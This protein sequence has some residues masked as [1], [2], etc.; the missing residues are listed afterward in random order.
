MVFY[1]TSR[2]LFEHYFLNFGSTRHSIRCS[3][4]RL[5]FSM[6]R[7]FEARRLNGSLVESFFVPTTSLGRS[8]A[9][10]EA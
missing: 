8:M 10:E 7:C 4:G 1:L 3:F 5:R 2:D 6:L 9:L